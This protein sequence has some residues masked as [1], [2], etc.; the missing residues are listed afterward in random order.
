METSLL[1]QT[2]TESQHGFLSFQ[3]SRDSNLYELLFR[4]S[5]LVFSIHFCKLSKKISWYQYQLIII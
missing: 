3:E 2:A 4:G 5:L 1:K